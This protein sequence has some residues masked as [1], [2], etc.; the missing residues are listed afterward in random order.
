MS[1]NEFINKLNKKD[2]ENFYRYSKIRGVQLYKIIYY[3]LNRISDNVSYQ[4]VNSF[5]K[6]DKA[7]KDVLYTYLGS[8]EEYIKVYI[9]A[10]YDFEA[11]VEH[12]K[13]SYLYFKDLPKT[14]NVKNNDN[15]ITELYKRSSLMFG[16][17]IEFLD[18]HNDK[19]FDIEKLKKVKFLRNDVMHHS[20]LIFDWNYNSKVDV[21]NDRIQSLID[22]LP[23]EYIGLSIEINKLTTKTIGNIDACFKEF[24]L[25][26]FKGK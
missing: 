13:Y 10:N 9:F 20:P 8:L 11:N 26:E 16:G 7:L 25:K 19:T 24:V 2:R 18:Y 4:D 5:I 3:S 14:I 17:L 6:Y 23:K 15:E 12:N 1:F 21:V 22:I